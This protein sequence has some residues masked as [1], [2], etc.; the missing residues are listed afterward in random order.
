MHTIKIIPLGGVRENGK[1][2]YIAEVGE[3]IFVLD[4]GLKYPENELLGIDVVIPDF[5]YL[6]ENV[7]R[8]AGVFLTHGHADSIGALPYLLSKLSVPVFGTELTIELAKLSVGR[9]EAAKRFK[10]FHVVD[11]HTEI[12]FGETVVSFFRTTHTIPDSV[13]INLKTKEGS[14]VYT[15]DFKF[16]Q[17]AIPMYQTDYVRLAEIGKEGVLALLS[18]SANAENPVPVASELQIADEVFDTI[19][20]WDGRIIV[21]CVASN[22]QRVQQILDAAD[23][24]QRK[25]VLTGQDFERIIR[26]AM[27]LEK[28]QLPHEDLLVT[29]KDMKKYRP[30]ELIILETGRMGEPIKSLQK[31]ANKTHRNIKIEEG[32]LVYIT[33]TPSIAMETMVAKTEDIVFRAGGT[34]KLISENMRVSGHANPNDLQL[35]LNFMKP[36]YFIPVQGEYRELA[37]HA[38][39]AH[40]VGIPYKN[41]YI[42]GRGDVLEYKNERMSVSGTISA[43]NV[44][45]DGLGIGDIGNIVLRDR[46]IL[47]E[48][49]IFVAV[50]T[51]SRREKKIISKPQ[52]TSRGFVYVKA[53]RD[54]MKESSTMIEEIVE[55]HLESNDFEWSKLKQDIRD[56]LGRYLFEQ[57][58]R[59]PVILPVIMEA[60]QRKSRK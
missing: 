30:E 32:D 40:T 56:Q 11:E 57:T 24:A 55:K 9:N 48:D 3:D 4:C 45:I 33:T 28:L 12:D 47:S 2:M 1:N 15:G 51:I 19:K 26:T 14:I 23:K 20:Y 5:T 41:I 34:V 50:V 46:K 25:V 17:T 43:E 13:G 59:R 18:E 10:D 6:E 37:A 7:E 60:A 29:L 44:M 39:L 21:A 27:R 52:I 42:T 35:M 38:D 16:D 8:V 58:R 49:G 36:T 31:M 53:S 54:L 22:L